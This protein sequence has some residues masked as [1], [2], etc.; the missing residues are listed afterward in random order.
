M[1]G[2]GAGCA[3]PPGEECCLLGPWMGPLVRWAV[4]EEH[5]WQVTE[6]VLPLPMASLAPA[7]VRR[8]HWQR[9]GSA[10]VTA[11]GVGE[12]QGQ[13]DSP[14]R[15]ARRPAHPPDAATARS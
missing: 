13:S 15:P 14:D 1:D 4:E 7:A 10:A 9:W 6:G 3:L 12:R 2:P 5:S 11:A 8:A